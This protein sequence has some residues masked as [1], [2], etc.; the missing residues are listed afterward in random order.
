MKIIIIQVYTE[1][2]VV[3]YKILKILFDTANTKAFDR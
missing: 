2:K 3:D 1:C